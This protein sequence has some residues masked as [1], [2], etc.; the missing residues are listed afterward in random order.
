MLTIR[1]QIKDLLKDEGFISV[2]KDFM[3]KLDDKVKEVVLK[4]AKRAR[5]NQRRTVMSRDI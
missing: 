1:T 3:D 2:S 5:D 4:A